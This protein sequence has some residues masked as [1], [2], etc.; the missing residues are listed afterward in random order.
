[1]TILLIIVG[2]LA[3]TFAF[4]GNG[5]AQDFF[6]HE[7]VGLAPD[8]QTTRE[9]VIQVYAARA[10]RWRGNFGVHTWIAVKPTDA[11]AFSVYE[12]IGWYAMRGEPSL[13]I[14]HRAPDGR[15]FGNAP[16]LLADKRG[17][18]V[19]EMIKRIDAAAHKYPYDQDYLIWPGPNS[20]TFTAFV[21]RDVPELRV[22]MPPT[23]IG[24]D[25]IPG[26][27]AAKTPSGTGYQV[28]LFGLLG[29]MVGI[30]EGLEVDV[31]GLTFG[32]DPKDLSIKL[33]LIGEVG[34]GSE[35]PKAAAETAGR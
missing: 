5:R 31:L 19:D 34:F 32:I 9:A 2:L 35:T 20:N 7:P 17:A 6:N 21:L 25:F 26:S 11:P 15:W 23:A 22:D 4:V 13:S 18:G 29:V 3:V 1:M 16:W 27:I 8:P 24:K 28:S 33:P 10:A 30:E 14:S 12:V